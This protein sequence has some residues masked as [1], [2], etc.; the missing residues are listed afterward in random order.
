MANGFDYKSPIDTL[1]SVTLPRFL[2]SE[3]NRQE[4]SRQFDERLAF[5]EQQALINQQQ[6]EKSFNL[7]KDQFE[8][9][10]GLQQTK[11]DEEFDEQ[12]MSTLENVRSYPDYEKQAKAIKD[13][14]KTDK[15]RTILDRGL[16][17]AQSNSQF[18]KREID[19]LANI[20]GDDFRDYAENRLSGRVNVSDA[21]FSRVAQNYISTK[22]TIRAEDSARFSQLYK[23]A[24]QAAEDLKSIIDFKD[25]KQI[26]DPATQKYLTERFPVLLGLSDDELD[27]RLKSTSTLLSESRQELYNFVKK[28]NLPTNEAFN[29]DL[30]KSTAGS[31]IGIE[32]F[33]SIM[34]STPKYEI[35]NYNSVDTKNLEGGSTVRIGDTTSGYVGVIND[36]GNITLTV[37]NADAEIIQKALA[38]DTGEDI[39]VDGNQAT[40][41]RDLSTAPVESVETKGDDEDAERRLA[42][43]YQTDEEAVQKTLLGFLTG[44]AV[45]Q[46]SDIPTISEGVKAAKDVS[47]SIVSGGTREQTQAVRNARYGINNAVNV[48]L[49]GKRKGLPEEE[50]SQANEEIKSLITEAAKTAENSNNPAVRR[51]LISLINNTHSRVN[52][53]IARMQKTDDD[54]SFFYDDTVALINAMK[55]KV[56]GN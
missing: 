23:T 45:N 14:L 34:G 42:N 35:P 20:L 52:K 11:E 12:L 18:T 36:D 43:K 6:A 17:T 40:D 7:R 21:D 24:N 39:Y 33:Q 4:R 44:G 29:P 22:A 30:A 38:E 28:S 1:L 48:L 56:S 46:S 32:T 31:S 27:K 10:Q 41:V 55:A 25:A 37:D 3:L 53:A 15:F 54:I 50:V 5:N 26:S 49:A 19:S 8:F 9:Q 16:I 2:D 13:R 47:E 51:N